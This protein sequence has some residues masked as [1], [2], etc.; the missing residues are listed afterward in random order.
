M[1]IKL[2][3]DGVGIV[4]SVACAIHC[5]LLPVILP[6]LPLF[7]VNIVHN[8]FFE[9]GMILLA[10]VVGIFSLYHGFI[11]H[12]HSYKPVVV[13]VFGFG[14]LISKQFFLLHD[15]IL[16]LLAVIFIISAHLY[17]YKMCKKNTCHSPHHKH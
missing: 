12:H 5:G 17:N 11:R 3:W 8:S 1:R 7:G 4:T 14:F 2:N 6:V 9:W 10:F 16:L 13:F 15:K